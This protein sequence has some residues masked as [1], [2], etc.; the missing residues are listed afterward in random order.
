MRRDS[1]AVETGAVK[2]RQ[3][4]KALRRKSRE[5]KEGVRIR[6]EGKGGRGANIG[7]W[8]WVRG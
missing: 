5:G 3:E 6:P 1:K 2:R 8:E 4:E 7:R